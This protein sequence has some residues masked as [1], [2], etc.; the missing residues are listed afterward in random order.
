MTEGPSAQAS[1]NVSTS[2]CTSA[3]DSGSFR[4]RQF[5]LPAVPLP[6]GFCRHGAMSVVEM[7]LCLGELHLPVSLDQQPLKRQL[8]F[9]VQ[10]CSDFLES[11]D[12]GAAA[13]SNEQPH[14]GVPKK[15]GS[16]SCTGGT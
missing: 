7:R 15:R 9:V 8:S 6:S 13:S 12:P 1:K 5:L 4:P 16:R 14:L 11:A 3:N 10:A 2:T